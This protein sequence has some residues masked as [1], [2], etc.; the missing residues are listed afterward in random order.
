[1]LEDSSEFVKGVI[2][3]IKQRWQTFAGVIF[4]CEENYI[5]TE[6]YRECGTSGQR[7][8][9]FVLHSPECTVPC[10]PCGK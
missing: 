7:Y 4:Y 8:K 6:D 10:H 3:I 5:K 2:V 9:E 1:M